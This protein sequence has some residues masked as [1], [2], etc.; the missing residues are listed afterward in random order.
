MAKEKKVPPKSQRTISVGIKKLHTEKFENSAENAVC[1]DTPCDP[2]AVRGAYRGFVDLVPK[3]S[4]LRK[5]D[6]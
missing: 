3:D 6:S 1:I 4:I 5:H 2:E